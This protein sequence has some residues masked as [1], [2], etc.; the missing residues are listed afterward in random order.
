[1]HFTVHYEILAFSKLREF[2]GWSKGE[3]LGRGEPELVVLRQAPERTRLSSLESDKPV[4]DESDL[5]EDSPGRLPALS[6]RVAGKTID[7]PADE[8][9]PSEQMAALRWFESAGFM[10][11]SLFCH[12]RT[13]DLGPHL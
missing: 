9:V 7:P 4:S 3:E 5:T 1:M 12:D 6:H 11:A 2:L 8:G 13:M 10:L